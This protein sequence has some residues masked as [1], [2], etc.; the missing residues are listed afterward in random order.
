MKFKKSFE[1]SSIL[2]MGLSLIAGAVNYVTLIYFGRIMAVDEY[3]KMSALTAFISNSGVFVSPISFM[4]CKVYADN[5]IDKRKIITLIR[6]V[7]IIEGIECI[8][9]LVFRDL[10][11]EYLDL[12]GLIGLLTVTASVVLA[13]LFSM[14]MATVQG[15]R[16]FTIYGFISIA[17]YFLEFLFGYVGI[18]LGKGAVGVLLGTCLAQ[19]ICCLFLWKI[20][21]SRRHVEELSFKYDYRK[22][23]LSYYGWSFL[24]LLVIYYISNAG[25]LLLAKIYCSNE[26]IGIYSVVMNL[27]KIMMYVASAIATVLLPMVVGV[28]DNA[29]RKAAIL[30]KAM[31]YTLAVSVLYAIVLVLLKEQVIMLLYGEKYVRAIGYIYYT[32]PFCIVLSLLTIFYQ[33]VLAV[34]N[35]KMFSI[36]IFGAGAVSTCIILVTRASLKRIPLILALILGIVLICSYLYEEKK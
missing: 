35:I 15:L 7:I 27:S 32:L 11:L 9:F 24:I 16:E 12:G 14:L 10:L 3:G 13:T 2:V 17:M 19:M 22:E 1:S 25:E 23:I 31:R 30:K 6:L 33:Y 34:G 36:V 26:E 18:R 21:R 28:K 4:L 20:I 29:S 8:A 5:Q